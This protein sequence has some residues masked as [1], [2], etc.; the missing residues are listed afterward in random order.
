ML[1]VKIADNYSTGKRVV[2]DLQRY[3]LVIENGKALEGYITGDEFVRECKDF[4][5]KYYRENGLLQ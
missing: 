5:T 4:V 1:T 2:N 3:R